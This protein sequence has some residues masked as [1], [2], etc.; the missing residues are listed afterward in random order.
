MRDI[1]TKLLLRGLKECLPLH[2]IKEF[3]YQGR[4]KNPI[5]LES[6]KINAEQMTMHRAHSTQESFDQIP[7]LESSLA[8]MPNVTQLQNLSS[9]FSSPLQEAPREAPKFDEKKVVVLYRDEERE[10]YIKEQEEERHRAMV[11]GLLIQAR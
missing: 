7:S 1:Y 2:R 10:R 8:D 4:A 6:S 5:Q 11:T 3:D 9:S